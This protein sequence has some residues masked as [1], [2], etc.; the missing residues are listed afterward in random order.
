MNIIKSLKEYLLETN[1]FFDR[2][3]DKGRLSEFLKRFPIYIITESNIGIK[4]SEEYARRL[5][6]K[7]E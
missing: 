5:I 1:D 3:Y 6:E 2:Y 7:Q 4:G